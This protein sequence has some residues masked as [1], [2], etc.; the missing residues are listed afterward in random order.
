M[1]FVKHVCRILNILHICI[2]V[3]SF[4]GRNIIKYELLSVSLNKHIYLVNIG[5][6]LYLCDKYVC[7]HE[8]SFTTPD[9][10]LAEMCGDSLVQLRLL[11]WDETTRWTTMSEKLPQEHGENIN[12]TATTLCI[13]NFFQ[14]CDRGLVTLFGM[15]PVRVSACYWLLWRFLC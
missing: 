10:E 5:L 14:L 8:G 12:M 3:K 9:A 4:N 11:I 7:N 13:N 6:D 15:Y 2:R 1:I